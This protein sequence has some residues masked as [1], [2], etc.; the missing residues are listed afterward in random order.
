[1]L[2]KAL[3]MIQRMSETQL[4]FTSSLLKF[5]YSLCEVQYLQM[6]FR[7]PFSYFFL[8]IHISEWISPFKS[9]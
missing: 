6:W 5:Y 7:N 8:L 3:E 1:M 9:V 4:L 2:Y